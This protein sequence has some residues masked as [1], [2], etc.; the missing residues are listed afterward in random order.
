MIKVFFLPVYVELCLKKTPLVTQNT[1]LMAILESQFQ[2]ECVT[3]G[4]Y[5]SFL[6]NLRAAGRELMSRIAKL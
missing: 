5:D 2:I 1:C 3:F 6:V 4:K